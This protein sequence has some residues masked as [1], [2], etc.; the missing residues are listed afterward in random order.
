MD[1]THAMLSST[2]KGSVS[3]QLFFTDV[4]QPERMEGF[5]KRAAKLGVLNEIYFLPIKLSGHDAYRVTYGVYPNSD[6]ARNSIATLPQRYQEAFA[7]TLHMLG[8]PQ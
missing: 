8:N 3:I 2:S 1:A 6:A 7:P 5:L 4:A